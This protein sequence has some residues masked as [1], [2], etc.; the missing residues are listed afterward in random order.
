MKEHFS[1]NGYPVSFTDFFI[2]N[3]LEKLYVKKE[4][5]LLAPKK[6]LTCVVTFL[7]NKSLQL[8][9][10][11]GSSVNKTVLFRTLKVVFRSQRKWNT[12]FWLK[13]TLS[14]KIRSFR[15]YRYTC[16]NCNNTY[17]SKTYCHFFTR[18]VNHVDVS[19]LKAKIHDHFKMIIF[20]DHIKMTVYFTKNDD[21]ILFHFNMKKLT[22]ST[23]FISK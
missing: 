8:R 17:Y 13:D 5:Y 12:L 22:C 23:F 21:L 3:Y 7:G 9:S 20:N 15:V 1:K 18:A 2:N 11:L 19:N 16:S 10:R 4:V 14:K 6:Q